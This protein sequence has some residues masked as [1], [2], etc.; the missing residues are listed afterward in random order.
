MKRGYRKR[1]F[2]II[3]IANGSDFCS[4]AF[5]TVIISLIIISIAVTFLQTFD[6]SAGFARLLY[7]TDTICMIIFSLEYALRLFTADL[8]YPESKHPIF[9]YVRSADAVIDLLSI[10]PFYLSQLVPPGI[11]VFRLIRV[12]RILKLFKINKY[13]DPMTFIVAVIKRKASQLLASVFLVMVLM[14]AASILMYYAEHGAQ[15]EAF[16]NAFSGLWWAVATLSTTGYGDI[17]PVTFLGR[18][19]GMLITIIGL[20]A[21]AIPTGI[22][23]AGFMEAA[24]NTSSADDSGVFAD[25]FRI[26]DLSKELISCPVYPGDPQPEIKRVMSISNGSDYNLSRI[27]FGSHAATHVDAPLHFY[28]DGNTVEQI[29]LSRCVGRCVVESVNSEV[30]PEKIVDIENRA[31]SAAAKRILFRGKF[32]INSEA[33]A[34]LNEIGILLIGVENETV[35]DNNIHY[36][37][38]RKNMVIIENLELSEVEDGEYFLFAAPLKIAEADGAPVRAV[39]VS[40]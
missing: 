20:F 35:G 33:A 40:V 38:L 18:I 31:S 24:S 11:I 12:S 5:D 39:L 14:F 4:K 19:I 3:Q 1:L 6:L 10:L 17:Y 25:N 13:S 36:E 22:L 2:E 30:T 28:E 8:L 37:L 7:I 26:Y 9:T 16:N 32:S 23:T 29:A 21:V 15:P 34:Y 27:I